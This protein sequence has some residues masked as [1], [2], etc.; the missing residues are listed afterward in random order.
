MKK[1][2]RT[3]RA[4]FLLFIWSVIIFLLFVPILESTH[5]RRGKSFVPGKLLTVL[6]L[7]NG[8]TSKN[9]PVSEAC[10]Q[11]H[12]PNKTV[13]CAFPGIY[14]QV[15]CWFNWHKSLPKSLVL[16]TLGTNLLFHKLDL[17]AQVRS[18]ASHRVRAKTRWI[19]KPRKHTNTEIPILRTTTQ[20]SQIITKGGTV[21]SFFY[22]S[23]YLSVS[24]VCSH[25]F[26]FWTWF[27]YYIN[28]LSRETVKNTILVTFFSGNSPKPSIRWFR[29]CEETSLDLKRTLPAVV[30][31]ISTP[32][33]ASTSLVR[34]ISHFQARQHGFS[35]ANYTLSCKISGNADFEARSEISSSMNLWRK[36]LLFFVFD[37][38]FCRK[39]FS[40]LPYVCS[41]FFACRNRENNVSK[42]RH[43]ILSL[44]GTGF[45]V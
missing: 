2:Q 18:Q 3:S 1:L 35:G 29:N 19:A 28:G 40:P 22:S 15:H 25:C 23:T 16:E 38:Q 45:S 20:Y 21:R 8:Y 27:M 33:Y 5:E 12:T 11:I 43:E 13:P 17:L 44:T 7:V 34:K 41:S 42:K 10:Y 31:Q 24:T 36:A 4:C 9:S 30:N 26:V 14:N 39:E 32:V 37:A 6:S